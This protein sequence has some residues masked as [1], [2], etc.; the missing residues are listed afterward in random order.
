MKVF[1]ALSQITFQSDFWVK[2]TVRHPFEARKILE[3]IVTVLA[4]A[5]VFN[6]I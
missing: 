2:L 6:D 3:A 4:I 1:V 5:T